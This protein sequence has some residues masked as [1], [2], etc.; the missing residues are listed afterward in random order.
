[1]KQQ[2]MPGID[3]RWK[4]SSRIHKQGVQALFFCR[5]AHYRHWVSWCCGTVVDATALRWLW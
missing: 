3:W 5:T 2:S 4:H 1:M